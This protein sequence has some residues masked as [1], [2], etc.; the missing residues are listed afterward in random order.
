MPVYN[1]P[2][3]DDAPAKA[4]ELVTPA[5]D[6]VEQLK[7][8]KQLLDSGIITQEEFDAKKRQLLNL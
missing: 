4:A 5:D 8:Y 7:K 1:A 6:V 2:S 3:Y